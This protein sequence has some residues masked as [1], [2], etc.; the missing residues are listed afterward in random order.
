MMNFI[1]DDEKKK[2]IEK[3]FVSFILIR[4]CTNENLSKNP[5]EINFS[6]SFSHPPS[7]LIF[8]FLSCR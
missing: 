6:R 3:M 1:I 4:P 2:K 5:A 7:F 8:S